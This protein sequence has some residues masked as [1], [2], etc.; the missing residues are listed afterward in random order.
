MKKATRQL[1]ALIL[2]LCAL[3]AAAMPACAASLDTP[4]EGPLAPEYV[5]LSLLR[6]N[7]TVSSG[8]ATCTATVKLKNGYTAYT[9]MRLQKS[10]DKSNWSNV[11]IWMSYSTTLNKTKSVS[12]GYYYRT[13]VTVRVYDANNNL[14][15][16]VTQNSGAVYY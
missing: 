7:C 13:Q 6:C 12:S 10:N 8:T 11:T 5:G 9:S 1:I 14:V 4:P 3:A 2:A 15:E 16:T